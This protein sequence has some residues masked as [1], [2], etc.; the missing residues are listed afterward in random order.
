[1][2]YQ[3]S[4][5][6]QHGNGV[7][8]ELTN[9]MVSLYVGELAPNTT[10][11]MLFAKFSWV[12]PIV[13][14]EVS[15]RVCR[16]TATRR[17]LGYAYINF[18]E[19][20][21]A[22]RA[23]YMMNFDMIQGRHCRIIWPRRDPSLKE[24]VLPVCCNWIFAK[25]DKAIDDKALY[26]TFSAFGNILACKVITD[27]HGASK[28][29]GFVQFETKQSSDM[30]INKVDGMLLNDKKIIVRKFISLKERVKQL[31]TSQSFTNIIVKNFGDDFTET[32]LRELFLPYGNIVSHRI[33]LD[34]E[35][36]ACN[37]GFVSFDSHESAVRA[38][39]DLNGKMMPNGK[40]LYCDRAQKK[41]EYLAYLRCKFN[42][43]KMG[44]RS[45]YQGVNLYVKN[46]DNE[47]D[48][49]RLRTEFA[50]FGSITSAKVMRHSN[51]ESKEFGFVCFTSPKEAAKAIFRM[52]GHAIVDKPLYVTLAQRKEERKAQ[53][54]VEHMEGV[55][56][57]LYVKNLDDEIDDERLR[58]EFAKFGRITSAKIM[59]HDNG[60]S[61]G[62]GFVCFT[63][64]EAATKA[65]SKMNGHV[66]VDNCKPLFVT[67]AQRKEERQAHL[68]VE[69]MKQYGSSTRRMNNR[70]AMSHTELFPKHKL[71]HKRK[72]RGRH[73][74][75]VTISRGMAFNPTK[76]Q[77][78]Q[79]RKQFA[80]NRVVQQLTGAKPKFNPNM[81]NQPITAAAGNKGIVGVGGRF[82][83]IQITSNKLSA[84]IPKQQKQILGEQL[85][86]LISQMDPGQAGKITGMLMKLD[87]SEIQQIL[88]SYQLLKLK[89]N[90][91]VMVLKAYEA[92]RTQTSE[93][94]AATPQQQK[95]LLGEHLFYSIN[96][97]YPEQAGKITGML[98]EM[99]NSEILHMLDSQELLKMKVEEAVTV[100]KDHK[101]N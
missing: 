7:T 85:F 45:H 64:P 5:K 29:H 67:L 56:R 62:F 35:G 24:S 71:E 2:I 1:M 3:F 22:K 50:K 54:A 14:I 69:H 8:E 53:L 81:R 34:D 32:Q 72:Q 94:S 97:I 52:N 9:R 15:I 60:E 59:R 13:S 98:L 86:Y 70:S 43:M 28:G 18:K 10:E 96:Q 82:Q 68:A 33:P 38:V 16:D 20:A 58:T 55:N 66:I 11:V 74:H 41:S 39:E 83:G 61:K 21:D 19:P 77:H 6:I 23:L 36:R 95:Q 4:S 93:L 49:E 37:F 75:N 99:D 31:C 17:S 79:Q 80:Q 89:V 47:I 84:N 12:G 101:E 48:N 27:E 91:A 46:L 78:T 40:Q 57:N 30:A 73:M 87:N 65:I 92:L 44:H 51:G 90:E 63:S 26:D 42:A 76:F 25:N 100:L 88:D